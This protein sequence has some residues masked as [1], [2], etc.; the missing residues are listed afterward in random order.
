MYNRRILINEEDRSRILGMHQNHAKR[1][2]LNFGRL[3]EAA[4]QPDNIQEFQDYMD[5]VSQTWNNGG[6]LNKGAGYGSFGPN[7]RTAWAAYGDQYEQSKA[8]QTT[9]SNL[10]TLLPTLSFY[11]KVNGQEQA[12]S[13]FNTIQDLET[14][15]TNKQV[16]LDTNV[17]NPATKQ[18]TALNQ[19]P[20]LEAIVEKIAQLAPDAEQVQEKPKND[21]PAVDA[22]LNTELGIAYQKMKTDGTDP[23]A[24]EKFFDW[25]ELAGKIPTDKKT[26]RNALGQKADTFG[27]RVASGFKGAIRG[28]TQGAKTGYQQQQV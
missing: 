10:E 23:K 11:L 17:W 9:G 18:K 3:N 26:F 12:P 15:V 19:T 21:N 4:P 27:G 25:L 8:N 6:T 13:K 1:F 14:A 20:G 2:N 5:T 7:T 28:L 22:W 16:T 24:I